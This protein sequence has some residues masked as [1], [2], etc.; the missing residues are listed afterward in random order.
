[1]ET[2]NNKPTTIN[3]HGADCDCVE[4]RECELLDCGCVRYPSHYDGRTV[5]QAYTQMR[6]CVEG[7]ESE[8]AS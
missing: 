6:D 5:Y 8:A 2:S 4:C 3:N 1:M 7:H